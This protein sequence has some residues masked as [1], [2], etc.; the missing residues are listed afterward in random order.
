MKSFKDIDEALSVKKEA[1]DFFYKR[2]YLGSLK[3]LDKAIHLL[4]EDLELQ[5]YESLCLYHLGSVDDAEKIISEIYTLD[6]NRVLAL[7]P[8]VYCI[9]LIRKKKYAKALKILKESLELVE[10]KNDPQIMNMLAYTLEKENKLV[11]AEEILKDILKL[12]PEDANA[13]N[14]LAFIYYRQNKNIDEALKLA[15]RALRKESSNPAY[16]DTLGVLYYKKED[17]ARASKTLK[18]A[19]ELDPQNKEIIEHL[20]EI[21]R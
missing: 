9:F 11:M 5:L 4:P 1:I 19:I 20:K 17:K 2:D 18:K 14:S 21:T 13:C 15:Q 7:V 10:N 12:Y 8:K 6:K 16:L 3:L